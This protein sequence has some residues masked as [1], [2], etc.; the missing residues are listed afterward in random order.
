MQDRTTT[1]ADFEQQLMQK[2]RLEGVQK[3][4]LKKAREFTRLMLGD[5]KPER[6]VRHSV[7]S[8]SVRV[9]ASL[10]CRAM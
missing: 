7:H 4:M 9:P 5:G 2:G 3:G 6:K 10:F 1:I 8:L